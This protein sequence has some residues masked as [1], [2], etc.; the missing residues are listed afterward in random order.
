MLGRVLILV[1]SMAWLCSSGFAKD[2]IAVLEP[3]GPLDR[4]ILM[5]LSDESRAA[6]VNTLPK[7][8]Y[9][10]LTRENMLVILRDNEVDLSC[11]EGECEVETGRN[12]GAK[13]VISGSVIHVDQVWILTIKIHETIRGALLGTSEARGPKTLALIDSV[14]KATSTMIRMAILGEK[15]GVFEAP[16]STTGVPSFA[17]SQA[18]SNA[19]FSRSGGVLGVAA[20]LREQQCDETAKVEGG[21]AR[22]ARLAAA[23]QEAQSKAKNAWAA[24]AEELEMCTRLKRAKRDACIDAVRAWLGVARSMAVSIPAGVEP[25]ETECGSR[26]PV[27][28][29]IE[30][31]VAGADVKTA[32]LLLTRLQS[33]DLKLAELLGLTVVGSTNSIGMEFVTIDRGR[34]E[35]GCTPE[36]AGCANKEKPAHTVTLNRG[37]QIQT[38]EVTQGQYRAVMG[39][40][41]SEFSTCGSDCPVETVSWHSAIKFANALSKKEGLVPAYSGTGDSIRW[42]ERANGY[43]LPTEAEWEYAARAGQATLYSGSN[44]VTDVAWI[45]S[46]SGNSTHKVGTKQPNGWGLYDMSGNVWEWCWDWYG[47]S[48][49]AS[50]PGADPGGVSFGDERIFR[51]GSWYSLTDSARVGFRFKYK[52]TMRS[53]YIGFRLIRPSP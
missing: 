1:I 50:S 32:E 25:V 42:D 18:F 22:K 9:R 41:P 51:G 39:E 48:Y 15:V 8:D 10:V 34:F 14:Q 28:E 24:Q 45:K 46:N 29:A 6:A 27:Y 17:P 7:D 26:Q 11:I 47:R 52:P 40:N 20:M 33:A 36:Q 21:K 53:Y 43:R 31:T 49:Y 2:V 19:D 44:E 13:Y 38:T 12:V 4:S 16:V 3:T 5:K 37:F 30:R 35:M 23:V